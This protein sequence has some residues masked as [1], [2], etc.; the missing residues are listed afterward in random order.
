VKHFEPPSHREHREENGAQSRK[1]SFEGQSEFISMPSVAIKNQTADCFAA[2]RA[3]VPLFP[4]YSVSVF[5]S[6]FI[7]HP[8][9]LSLLQPFW[10]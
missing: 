5:A 9:A 7:L 8:F 2:L 1:E 6:S 3:I 4:Q 10:C